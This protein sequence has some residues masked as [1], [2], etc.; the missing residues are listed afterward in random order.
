MDPDIKYLIDEEQ[1][2]TR[3]L[4]DARAAARNRIESS[5]LA[6]AEQKSSEFERIS[7]EFNKMTEIKLNEIRSAMDSESR[8]LRMEQERLIDDA[9]LRDKITGRI[10]SLILENR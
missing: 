4:E 9:K 2:L 1:K 7:S 3:T 10:V 6:A 5:R 8:E